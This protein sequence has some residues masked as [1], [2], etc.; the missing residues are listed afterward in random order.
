MP[1]IP[2]SQSNSDSNIKV[3]ST[4]RINTPEMGLASITASKQAQEGLSEA[5]R[6]IG[7]T[8]A[9]VQDAQ[10][11]VRDFRQVNEASVY[12]SEQ[13]SNLH[14]LA[15][16]DPNIDPA[17]YA[18][19]LDKL[20]TEAAKTISSPLAKEEFMAKAKQQNIVINYGIRDLY[21][22]QQIEGAKAVVLLK[23]Q[24]LEDN[25]GGMDQ[26]SRDTA[27]IDFKMTLEDAIKKGV[28]NKAEAQLLWEK[29]QN[30]INENIVKYDIYNDPATQ[31]KDSITL[32]ELKSGKDGKYG[33][34]N[35]SDRLALIQDS[36]R[37]IFQNNQTYKRENELSKDTR[38]NNIFDK[39]NQGTLTLQDID[40]EFQTSE[41]E[42]GIP[43]K[44]LLEIKKGIETRVK[45][46][47]EVIIGNNDKAEE[48]L[49]FIDNFI[50]DESDRQKGREYLAG[51]YGDKI[52]SSQEA[53]FL[54]KIKAEAGDIESNRALENAPKWL[55]LVT[56][57]KALREGIKGRKTHTDSEAA[58]AI[59]QLLN[60]M[61]QG[62]NST[63][64]IKNILYQDAIKRNPALLNIPKDGQLH[65]DTDGS[66]KI[67]LPDTTTKEPEGRKYMES[68]EKK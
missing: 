22:T 28:Y 9:E 18:T 14:T 35:S 5:I 12:H 63:E 68:M 17:K 48:Y 25:A 58:F 47:L 52:L 44:Q 32:A 64:L 40:N 20:T 26:V 43:K 56:A 30:K 23:G 3:G 13:T 53:S 15:K 49:K 59:K 39:Q 38:F 62:K 10:D 8:M 34:L 42:G 36:Q 55:G 60:G 7:K 31:E 11:K 24:Q 61:G 1:R 37:R 33:F 66:L 4:P 2:Q 41:K 50:N 16:N 65:L 27:G 6:G 67:V 19:E 45:N 21:R 54:N 46:A 57:I 29:T 51:A